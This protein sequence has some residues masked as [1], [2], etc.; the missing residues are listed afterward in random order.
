MHYTYVL[1]YGHEE[2]LQQTYQ[3]LKA[4]LNPSQVRVSG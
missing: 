4:F 1:S 2:T 3:Y